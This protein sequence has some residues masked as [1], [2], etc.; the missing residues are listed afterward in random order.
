MPRPFPSLR[1][2][3]WGCAARLL[4]SERASHPPTHVRLSLGYARAPGCAASRSAI[5]PP[6]AAFFRLSGLAH[7]RLIALKAGVL[8]QD[9]IAG[10]T[11]RLV[12]GN[13]LVVYLPRVGLTQVAHPLGLGVYY[14]HL[15]V[16]GGLVFATV[17]LG[18]SFRALRAL[19]ATVCPVNDQLRCRSFAASVVSSLARPAFRHHLQGLQGLL[20]QGQQVMHPVVHPRLAQ[21]EHL[22]QQRLQGI[23]FLVHQDKEQFLLG[24]A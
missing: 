16:A 24:R 9:C 15:L 2:A 12:V 19:T 23:G 20:Q 7:G 1:R 17:V 14:H 6:G 10:I 21:L 8:I 3:L 5:R 18:L 22:A 4:Q 11:E 13:L